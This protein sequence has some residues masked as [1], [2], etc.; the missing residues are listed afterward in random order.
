MNFLHSKGHVHR[1][2]KLANI[3]MDK[4]FNMKLTDFGCA[5]YEF[6]NSEEPEMPKLMHMKTVK[7]T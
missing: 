4:D 3:C 2:I 6:K 5:A 1:D 7:G